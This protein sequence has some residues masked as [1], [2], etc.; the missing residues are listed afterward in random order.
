ML[1]SG[2]QNRTV[3]F[4]RL[5]SLRASEDQIFG[6][7]LRTAISRAY[8]T[9]TQRLAE[10][11]RKTP[12]NNHEELV[13]TPAF[14]DDWERFLSAQ[15]TSE[16]LAAATASDGCF[17]VGGT[18]SPGRSGGEGVRA[19]LVS[20]PQQEMVLEPIAS[21]ADVSS[22]MIG[23][24]R[25]VLL[26]LAAG[27]LLGRRYVAMRPYRSGERRLQNEVRV[28]V[29][30]GSSSMLGPRGRMRD[31]LLVAELSTLRARMSDANRAGNQVLYYRYF[32]DEV[33]DTRR[34][35]SPEEALQA[36]DDVLGQLR[37]GGTNIQKALLASFEQIRLAAADDPDL[38]RAQIVLVTDGEAGIDEPALN[39]AREAVGAVP[40]GVS[41][42]AVGAQNPE[43]RKL[44]ARQRAQGEH[45]FYQFIDDDELRAIAEGETAGLPLHLPA[46]AG[47]QELTGELRAVLSDID[48]HLRRIDA[49]QIGRAADM[50]AAFREV[51]LPAEN[52][53]EQ[54]IRARLA[55]IENDRVSLDAAFV[56][57][58]PPVPPPDPQAAEPPSLEALAASPHL[59]EVVSALTTV[60][61]VVESFG[62]GAVERKADALELLERLLGEARVPPWEYAELIRQP[63]APVKSALRAVHA[64]A[65]FGAS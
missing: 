49:D 13:F 23:D 12:A 27:R 36:V 59:A 1:A 29:L 47:W 55:A 14:F 16:L 33:A 50:A 45:V 7:A 15:A 54:R 6:S 25:S 28:Y 32:N 17:E 5:Q 60:A 3:R 10:L 11:R 40:V 39:R 65:R 34:V 58:F 4:N 63:P 35:A 44:A 26:D 37:Y 51:G 62:A 22:A 56:R 38:A 30:D 9:A 43:L 2:A 18:V 53:L 61:E 21:V 8:A 31:A 48:R 42:I 20:F 19:E 41:I 46:D 24:P 52:G 64:A 57:A